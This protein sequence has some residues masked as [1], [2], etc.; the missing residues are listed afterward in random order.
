M[1][2]WK[3]FV[4]AFFVAISAPSTAWAVT[5]L[6]LGDSLTEGYGVTKTEAWPSVAEKLL[7][8][9]KLDVT[10]VN[11]GISGSTTASA[12]SRLKWY[13][14]SKQKFDWMILALGA[15]DGLR[16]Q[17]VKGIKKNLVG[18]VEAARKAGVKKVILAGMRIPTNYGSAYSRDFEKIYPDISKDMSLPLIPFLLD[19]VAA[20][21]ELNLPDGIHPNARG[22]QIVAGLVAKFVE[23]QL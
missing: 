18:A 16:G 9:K 13:F 20:K 12:Q 7:R 23:A 2:T 17:D 1:K 3:T 5:I 22:H 4:V 21:P 19:G 15:N 8:D 10:F 11:A 6:C 14:K